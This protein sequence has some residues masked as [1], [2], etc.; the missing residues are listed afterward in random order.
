MFDE[1]TAMAM[2]ASLIDEIQDSS[3]PKLVNRQLRALTRITDLFMAGSGRHSKEQIELFDEIFK[4]LVA[5]IE[6]K[7]RIKL[8][9]HLATN[10]NAPATL[11]RAFALDNA[12]AVAAPVLSHSTALEDSDLVVNASTQRSM[13]SGTSA[14]VRN[15]ALSFSR[16]T[17]LGS[18]LIFQASCPWPT[19]M[20]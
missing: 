5:A 14:R 4:T 12:I 6:V 15:R 18:L 7:T 2:F 9:H 1:T 10:P 17:T 20:A 13:G 3:V 8:A 11:V 16:T 19:S